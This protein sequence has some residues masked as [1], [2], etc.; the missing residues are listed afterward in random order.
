MR[1][2]PTLQPDRAHART[3]ETKRFPGWAA[4]QPLIN[5][6]EKSSKY[7]INF[8]VTKNIQDNAKFL[9][10]NNT[11]IL[12]KLFFNQSEEVIFRSFSTVLKKISSRYYPSRGKSI[13]DSILK[14]NSTKYKKFTI[15]GCYVEK[16]KETV[17]IT[18][19]N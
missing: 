13:S 8:Y 15:G 12:S 16:I 10:K 5:N 2:I 1:R 7:S 14:I 3:N 11:Y 19:E 9:K 6:H 4:P 18:K 17:L